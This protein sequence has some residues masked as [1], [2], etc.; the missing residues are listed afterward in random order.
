MAAPAVLM[1]FHGW[2]CPLT[3]TEVQKILE[4]ACGDG[5]W[6]VSLSDGEGHIYAEVTRASDSA[7]EGRDEPHDNTEVC[8]AVLVGNSA[9]AALHVVGPARLRARLNEAARLASAWIAYAWKTALETDSLAREIVRSYE[10]LHLLYELGGGLTSHQ[11]VSAAADLILEKTLL[12]VPAAQAVIRLQ[13]PEEQVYVKHSPPT[14]PDSAR[15][16]IDGQS[17]STTLRSRGIVLG[18]IVLSRSQDDG[19]FTS[20]DGKLLDGVGALAGNAIHSAQLYEELRRQGETRLRAVMDNVAEGIITVDGQGTVES[21]NPAAEQIFGYAAAEVIDQDFALLLPENLRTE[22]GGD[23]GN[24]L[25]LGKSNVVGATPHQMQGKRKDGEIFPMDMSVS[26]V[27]FD[28]QP[29]FIVSVRD[30]TERQQWEEALRHQALHDALTGFPNRTL[31]YD[32]IQQVIVARHES[33]AFLALLVMDLDRFKEVND[34]FGH[35]YGDLLLKQ[36]G[37]RLRKVLRPADTVARLGGDEFAV[38]LPGANVRDAT[39]T[40]ARLLRAL[41]QPFPINGHLLDVTA[42]I[43]IA[44]CPEHGRDADTLLRQADVAMYVAKSNHSEYSVYA[45]EQDHHSINR[46]KLISELRFAIEQNELILYY[47]PKACLKDGEVTWVEALV[48]WRH[49]ELGLIL[50]NDFIPLAELTGLIRQLSQWVLNAALQQCRAWMDAGLDIGVAVNLSAQNLQDWRL[51]DV[52]TTAF[53]TWGV[54]HNKLILEITESALMA[55]PAESLGILTRLR[56]LDVRIAIDDFGTG[57]SSMAYLQQ[58]PVQEIKIDKSFVLDMKSNDNDTA[59]VRTIIGLGHDLGLT[60]TAE[61]VEDQA[62][63]K[64]LASL[65]CDI[66]QGYYLSYPLPASELTRWLGDRQAQRAAH[67]TVRT[68]SR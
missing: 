37:P 55:D 15:P 59:I 21:F 48:R 34:T 1:G 39:A 19:P 4:S 35:H 16:G 22:Y 65:G 11:S 24:Y 51:P 49:P 68:G 9:A 64:M 12:T 14:A 67:E 28:A 36:I 60:V 26:H 63:W 44:L 40:A 62:T 27:S 38:L 13:S 46:L 43:G 58:L 23:L 56:N 10:E 2:D 53:E 32:R 52:V 54:P 7:G 50:P 18:T 30:I 33:E 29:L 66:A 61:G 31:L 45:A 20:V 25:R 57:Y 47:Q 6:R 42:S 41:R 5:I 3:K 8:A 17:I